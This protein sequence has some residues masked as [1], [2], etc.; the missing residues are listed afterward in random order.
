M[1]SPTTPQLVFEY[2]L[3]GIKLRKLHIS[4]RSFTYSILILGINKIFNQFNF[5]FCFTPPPPLIVLTLLD[6]LRLKVL[7][8]SDKVRHE[9]TR[10]KEHKNILFRKKEKEHRNINCLKKM[11]KTRKLQ[12]AH[13]EHL[14]S[15][16]MS[17]IIQCN[18]GKEVICILVAVLLIL[19]LGNLV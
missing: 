5:K 2:F 17:E 10:L 4:F 11:S 18:Q 19:M 15:S 16:L 6:F 12:I 9:M 1:E 14:K 3:S 8:S 7:S 13:F